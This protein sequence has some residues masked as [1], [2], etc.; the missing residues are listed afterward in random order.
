[1]SWVADWMTK[2]LIKKHR[3]RVDTLDRESL[4]RDKDD[5]DKEPRIKCVSTYSHVSEEIRNLIRREWHI[6]GVTVGNV[7]EFRW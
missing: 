3:M 2:P 7:K 6:L 5:T 4:L 1:M